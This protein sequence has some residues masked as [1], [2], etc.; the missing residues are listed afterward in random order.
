MA[1]L[2]I[3][4]RAGSPTARHFMYLSTAVC[5]PYTVKTSRCP[6]WNPDPE[7]DPTMLKYLWV[8][9]VA[10]YHFIDDDDDDGDDDDRQY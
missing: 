4:F 7:N 3:N 5:L 6:G 1:S 8:G 9:L 2:P 10:D